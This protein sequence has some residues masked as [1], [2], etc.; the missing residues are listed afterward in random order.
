MLGRPQA[1][2]FRPRTLGADMGY[3]TTAFVGTM[4]TRW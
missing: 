2:G 3:D 1:R 4:R